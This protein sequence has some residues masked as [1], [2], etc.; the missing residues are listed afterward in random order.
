MRVLAKKTQN[1]KGGLRTYFL[2]VAP[3]GADGRPEG[4]GG[5]QPGSQST[6]VFRGASAKVVE[7]LGLYSKSQVGVKSVFS[8]GGTL[9]ARWRPRGAR[10]QPGRQPGHFWL[11]ICFPR[12]PPGGPDGGRRQPGRQPVNRFFLARLCESS[13]IPWFI[14]NIG[15]GG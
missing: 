15:K 1:R 10:R 5:S 11:N 9:G 12:V 7:I 14:R 2:R 13:E 3:W 4:P 6:I 8:Q